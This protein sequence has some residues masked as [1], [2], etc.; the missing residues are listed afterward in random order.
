M[1][2][3]ANA[4]LFLQVYDNHSSAQ[5]TAVEQDIQFIHS[6]TPWPRINFFGGTNILFHDI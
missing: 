1:Q 3:F 4:A 6:L 5:P 2:F